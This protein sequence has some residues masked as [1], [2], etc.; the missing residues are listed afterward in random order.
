MANKT[1]DMYGEPGADSP[2]VS[3]DVPISERQQEVI[4]AV[5]LGNTI[6]GKKWYRTPLKR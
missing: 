2:P 1:V 4:S 6:P 3:A 5:R